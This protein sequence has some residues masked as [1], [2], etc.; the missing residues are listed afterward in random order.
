MSGT[1]FERQPD[2]PSRYYFVYD[3]DADSKP[4]PGLLDLNGP[5][6]NVSFYSQQRRG[7]YVASLVKQYLDSGDSSKTANKNVLIVGAGLSGATCYLALKSLGVEGVVLAE[8][9]NNAFTKQEHASHRF[10]H[11]SLAEWPL[12]EAFNST[13]NLPFL[14]WHSGPIDEVAA[15]IKRDPVWQR[16]LGNPDANNDLL[17]STNI[18]DVTK[19]DNRFLVQGYALDSHGMRKELL[20]ASYACVVF[21]TGYQEYEG[22]ADYAGY[23]EENRAARA[24]AVSDKNLDRPLVVVG[25]GDGAI[26]EL[27]NI[28]VKDSKIE[29]LLVA[30]V[31][32][33]RDD[34][35][36]KFDDPELPKRSAFETRFK[37][38]LEE[39]FRNQQNFDTGIRSALLPSKSKIKEVLKGQAQYNHS[40][41]RMEAFLVSQK[42]P[43]LS[44][45]CSPISLLAYTLMLDPY[46]HE[47]WG[48]DNHRIALE[49]IRR[50]YPNAGS[51]TEFDDSVVQVRSKRKPNFFFR[52]FAKT[53][54]ELFGFRNPE[55]RNS[56]IGLGENFRTGDYETAQKKGT[57]YFAAMGLGGSP[58]KNIDL[59]VEYKLDL[60]KKYCD[61]HF[62][63]SVVSRRR[64]ETFIYLDFEQ[65]KSKYRNMGGFDFELYGETVRYRSKRDLTR[66]LSAEVSGENEG[67]AT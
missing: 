26:I 25:N 57:Y 65:N 66:V 52:H 27:G 44:N 11:P 59:W 38:L 32:E 33:L 63:G 30:L 37:T 61:G 2:D 53:K 10:A 20:D 64:E 13:T 60:A 47:Y 35:V 21:A 51:G 23:W 4:I 15:Q 55:E 36:R 6:G 31:S 24:T 12:A 43:F 5:I 3:S 18:T 46:L 8:I 56:D 58:E 42:H 16:Y 29:P 1:L 45:K 14:N 54:I 7:F 19:D 50:N 28:F 39:K 48:L 22:V 49:H 62:A 67:A 34:H 40:Q 41:S 9:A 17:F